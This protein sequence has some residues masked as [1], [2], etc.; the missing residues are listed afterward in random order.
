MTTSERDEVY[1]NLPTLK[2]L[3]GTLAI[4][5]KLNPE[6]IQATHIIVDEA[7]QSTEP[8][9]LMAWPRLLRPGGQLILCGD[10][11]QLGPG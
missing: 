7:S 5:G 2:I 1:A 6:L 9:V 3:C 4:L 8:E 11:H 10:P